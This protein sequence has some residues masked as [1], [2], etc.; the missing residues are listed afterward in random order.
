MPD[1]P[2]SMRIELHDKSGKLGAVEVDPAR[3]PGVVRLRK[4]PG[5][6]VEHYLEWE[7]AFDDEGQLRR[8]P[9]CGSESLYWR[10]IFQPLTG[11]IVVLI[12]GLVAVLLYGVTNAPLWLIA[13]SLAVV[14]FINGLIVRFSPRF[15]GCY[16]CGTRFRGVKVAKQ[17]GEWDSATAAS[18]ANVDSIPPGGK[19]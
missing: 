3:P 2:A 10:R 19:P 5:G 13:G 9:A 6:E 7:R 17:W 11:F 12:V 1:N 4:A 8:C 14:I 18:I 15:M 16:R